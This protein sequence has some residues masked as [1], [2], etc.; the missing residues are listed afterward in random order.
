MKSS[1]ARSAGLTLPAIVLAGG[2]GLCPALADVVP[3]EEHCV[4]NVRGSDALNVRSGPNPHS[5]I[6]TRKRYDDCGI[7]VTGACRGSWCPVED[8]HHAGWVHSRY[9]GMVSPALYCVSGLEKGDL[10]NLRAWPSAT[11]QILT[12]LAPT[13]C[14]IAFLPYSV[15]SWQKIRVGGWQGWANRRF[16]SGE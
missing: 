10:L 12:R 11:S 3:G 5:R 4:V 7:K 1:R 14:E 2:I 16:L 9:I 15:G 8:G 13:Q 6:V